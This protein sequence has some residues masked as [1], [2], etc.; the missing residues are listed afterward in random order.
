MAQTREVGIVNQVLGLQIPVTDDGSHKRG[1]HTT[2]VD[3]HV[4]DLEAAVAL[5]LG[6][7]QCLRAFLGCFGL[8]VVIQLT[9]NGLQVAFE[10][11]ITTGD[12]QQGDYSKDE[13]P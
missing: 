11:T 10:E 5:F 9:H 3:E 4:E 12:E 2:N 13:R 8:E 6:S 1:D 7:S